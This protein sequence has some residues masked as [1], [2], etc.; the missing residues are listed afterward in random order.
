VTQDTIKNLPQ[1]S[2]TTFTDLMRNGVSEGIEA[3]KADI[4][5]KRKAVTGKT[6]EAFVSKVSKRYDD[7]MN[8]IDLKKDGNDIVVS[9]IERNPQVLVDTAT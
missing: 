4:I 8:D 3:H 9:R 1:D 6:D 7:G 5:N 2:K